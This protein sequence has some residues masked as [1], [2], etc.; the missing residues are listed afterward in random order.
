[1]TDDEVQEKED[2]LEEAFHDWSKKDFQ[3]FVKACAEYGR[4]NLAVCYAPIKGQYNFKL[5]VEISIFFFKFLFSLIG[6]RILLNLWKTRLLRK[7]KNIQKSFGKDTK[8][9]LI[10]KGILELDE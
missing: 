3:T 2:L 1:M 6:C 8:N 4:K 7:L 10:G 5:G 9:C